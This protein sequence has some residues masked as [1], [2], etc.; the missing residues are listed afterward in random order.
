[1]D[2]KEVKGKR[3]EDWMENE[4]NNNIVEE[5]NLREIKNNKKKMKQT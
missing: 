1:M 4:D 5:Y 2:K 3:E